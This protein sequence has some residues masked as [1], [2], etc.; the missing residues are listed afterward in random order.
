[1][2]LGALDTDE[3]ARHEPQYL[4]QWPCAETSTRGCLVRASP[5]SRCLCQHLWQEESADHPET[6]SDKHR[7]VGWS[8]IF[9]N[10]SDKDLRGSEDWTV[11]TIST[12]LLWLRAWKN[13]AVG[14]ST[15]LTLLWS[16]RLSVWR[17]AWWRQ[18]LNHGFDHHCHPVLIRALKS[19]G[20]HE[21]E[22]TGTYVESYLK[23]IFRRKILYQLLE[24]LVTLSFLGFDFY[25]LQRK[26]Y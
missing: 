3:E 19:L 8:Y 24:L 14:A 11:H 1:M 16:W 23:A 21:T 5:Q 22:M 12:V 10:C 26:G 18:K 13:P 17:I 25:I 4:G 6:L 9:R 2:V 7:S 15:D 20:N